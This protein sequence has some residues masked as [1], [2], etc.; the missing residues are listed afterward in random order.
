MNRLALNFGRKISMATIF[1]GL[2]VL[3]VLTAN[4]QD[5]D[6]PPA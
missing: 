6:D 4:A 3:V 2:L 5:N 1:A